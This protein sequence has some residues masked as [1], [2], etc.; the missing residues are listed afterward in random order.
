MAAIITILNMKGSPSLAT[1]LCDARD[2]ASCYLN[3]SGRGEAAEESGLLGSFW[4]G[5]T[6]LLTCGG[7]REEVMPDAA[8]K[9]FAEH[10]ARRRKPAFS[11]ELNVRRRRP[12]VCEEVYWRFVHG[13][14][15]NQH[16]CQAT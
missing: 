4:D 3:N 5:L 9:R 2:P 11:E 7:K 15:H 1:L 13:A 12:A 10:N 14:R 16:Q 6:S 8:R